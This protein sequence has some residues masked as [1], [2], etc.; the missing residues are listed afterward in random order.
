MRV[1]LSRSTKKTHLQLDSKHPNT[2]T[3]HTTQA[4]LSSTSSLRTTTTPPPDVA[5]PHGGACLGAAALGC[6]GAGAAGTG[7]ASGGSSGGGCVVV[8]IYVCFI[9]GVAVGLNACIYT[10]VM[11]YIRGRWLVRRASVHPSYDSIT[12]HTYRAASG[13][14]RWGGASG[15]GGALVHGGGRHPGRCV[16]FYLLAKTWLDM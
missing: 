15:G 4:T 13:G 16:A 1:H 9:W 8:C 2:S 14:G 12:T 6:D 3:N 11:A 10:V 7:A 5:G